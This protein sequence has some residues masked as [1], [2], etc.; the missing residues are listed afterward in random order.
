MLGV[1][2]KP[3]WSLCLDGKAALETPTELAASSDQ[4]HRDSPLTDVCSVVPGRFLRGR[5]QMRLCFVLPT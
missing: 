5:K 1:N 4:T 3:V 2:I